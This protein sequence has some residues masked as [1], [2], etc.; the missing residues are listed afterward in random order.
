[1]LVICTVDAATPQTQWVTPRRS[2]K[3]PAGDGTSKQKKTPSY[4]A[5]GF[6]QV[7][8]FATPTRPPPTPHHPRMPRQHVDTSH[9]NPLREQRLGLPPDR[10][11]VVAKTANNAPLPKM[12]TFGEG[13]ND[14]P[15]PKRDKSLDLPRRPSLLAH[16]QA[17]V[18]VTKQLTPNPKN[19]AEWFMDAVVSPSR[20]FEEVEPTKE[21]EPD[22]K[23]WLRPNRVEGVKSG[24]QANAATVA[25]PLSLGFRV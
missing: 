6:P 14:P 11:P 23:L 4:R 1:M 24:L 18:S 22:H 16:R 8:D 3:Q 2:P 5:R 13:A 25:N 20:L 21:G 7:L 10:D 9:S 19:E 17:P 12:P 15:L